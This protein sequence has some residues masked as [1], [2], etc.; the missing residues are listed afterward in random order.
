MLKEIG[1]I[2]LGA[3]VGLLIYG[4]LKKMQPTWFL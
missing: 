1:K 4:Q 3:I 2:A